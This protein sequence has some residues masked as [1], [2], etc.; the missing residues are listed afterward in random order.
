A[1]ADAFAY[2]RTSHCVSW[3]PIYH[4]MGLIGGVLQPLFGG[5]PCT[6]LSPVSFLQRPARWLRAISDCSA[7]ISG[8]PNFA[9]DMCVQK[10]SSD[11]KAGLDLSSWSVAFNGSEPVRKSTIE[12]FALAFEPCGFRRESLYPCYGLAEATL[13]V[14]GG[15]AGKRTA[16]WTVGKHELKANS[17]VPSK[18]DREKAHLVSCGTTRTGHTVAIVEPQSRSLSPAGQVGEIW[19]SGP[20]VAQGYWSRIAET[21][22]TFEA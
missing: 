22:A 18:D 21:A 12:A 20:S 8:G 5:F 17:I 19:V 11:E 6:L 1:L 10:I 4:D 14:T 16:I 2:D 13:F 9:Y 15:L 3:L 7:T